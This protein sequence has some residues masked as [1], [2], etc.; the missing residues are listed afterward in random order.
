MKYRCT[1]CT[2]TRYFASTNGRQII[3]IGEKKRLVLYIIQASKFLHLYIFGTAET[4][5][6]EEVSTHGSLPNS[7]I[8]WILESISLKDTI[9]DLRLLFY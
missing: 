9:L 6:F 1:N 7:F 3:F 5:D 2:E 8:F 4:N